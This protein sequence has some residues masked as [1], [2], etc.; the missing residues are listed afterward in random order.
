MLMVM[1]LAAKEGIRPA[2]LFI[3]G[4][5]TGVWFHTLLLLLGISALIMTVP[6]ALRL[7]ATFGMLYLL[8]LAVITFKERHQSVQH[9]DSVKANPNG[10]GS[11]F[12][13]GVIMNISNPK[14]LLFFLAFFP[15]FAQLNEAGYQAR[16]VLLAVIFIVCSFL[17]FAVIAWLTSAIGQKHMTNPR[18][19]TLMDWFSIGVFVILALWMLFSLVL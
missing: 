7:M 4:L 8:Y 6:G 2:L 1:A 3:T 16:I 5:V 18:Y 13:R 14:V 19:K 11:R 17:A 15:Q 9:V 10:G 12:W